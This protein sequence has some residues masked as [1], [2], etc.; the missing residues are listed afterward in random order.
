MEKYV[1]SL[2]HMQTQAVGLLHTLTHFL[3]HHQPQQ[4]LYVVLNNLPDW[5]YQALS[6]SAPV[7]TT[8]FTRNAQKLDFLCHLEIQL[9]INI[10]ITLQSSSGTGL[11]FSLRRNFPF[12]NP[13]SFICPWTG[14]TLQRCPTSPQE[15]HQTH[16]AIKPRQQR[17]ALTRGLETSEWFIHHRKA[18]TNQ[19]LH[20]QPTQAL[21]CV[22]IRCY[23][24]TVQS[25]TSDSTLLASKVL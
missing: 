11:L 15:S 16:Q 1:T 17:G 18:S 13:P 21:R 14:D 8:P 5:Q 12:W 20:T 10:L 9:T 2:Q 19:T 4:L 23:V 3:F 25:S 24:S 22:Y 7:W 6:C